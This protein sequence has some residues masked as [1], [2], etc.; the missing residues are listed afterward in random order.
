MTEEREIT[1]EGIVKLGRLA[2]LEVGG[3]EAQ[4]LSGQLSEILGYV[5]Q[6]DHYDVSNIKPMSHV[7]GSSNVYSADVLEPLMNAEVIRQIAPDASGNFFRTPIIVA[8]E[9]G[10]G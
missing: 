8:Q 5:R 7:H 1:E 6:L 4:K 10:E 3:E 9:G 2:R